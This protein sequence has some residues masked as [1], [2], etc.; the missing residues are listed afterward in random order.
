MKGRNF[1]CQNQARMI[2]KDLRESQSLLK[3]KSMFYAINVL[4]IFQLS[5]AYQMKMYAG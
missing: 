4:D 2:Y 5:D 1:L 3:K